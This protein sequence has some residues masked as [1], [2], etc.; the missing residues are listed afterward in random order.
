MCRRR[1]SNEKH[2]G[3]EI[4]G[5]LPLYVDERI[6]RKRSFSANNFQR[7]VSLARRVRL[8]LT[9][10]FLIGVGGGGGKVHFTLHFF[11]QIIIFWASKADFASYS[12]SN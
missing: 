6:S 10:I 4:F 2:Y 1:I 5:L 3:G 8:F 7:I 12:S 11:R 9:K